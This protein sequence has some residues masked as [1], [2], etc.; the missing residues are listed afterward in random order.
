MS[1]NSKIIYTLTDEAPALATASLLPIIKAFTGAADI[2]VET[3][4]ISLAGRI[5]ANFSDRL[6]AEQQTIDALTE[7]GQIAKLPEA[8]IVKLPN[9]SAS[10][11]QLESAIAELQAHGYDIPNYPSNPQSDED[12][13]NKA[14][15]AKVL[16]SAVNPVLREGNSDRRAPLSVKSY[17]K[18]NPHSMG[19]WSANSKTV[20]ASMSEGDFYGSEKSTT[21][22]KETQ[23][24]IQFEA[25]DGSIEELKA[26]ASLQ[27]GEVIDA[28]I[29]SQ[30]SLRSFLSN[31][32]SQAKEEN[33]LFSVHM[34]ATMMKVSDPIIFGQVVSVFFKEVF[35]KH[36]STF[37]EL[38][39]SA[40]NGLGDVLT[41]IESLDSSKQAEILADI[42]AVYAKRA[43]VAMVNSDKGITNLN[44]PSDVIIDASMPA[45]IRTSGQMWNKNGELQDTMAVIPD[46]CY[47]GVFKET[48]EFC[49]EHGAF[50]PTT[51]GSVS[52]VGLMAQKAQ[53]YGSHDKTF[54]MPTAGVVRVISDDNQTLLEQ[55][56]ESGDIFRMCQVKDAPIQDW[57]KLAVNR[58]RSTSS[59][60][61]FWLDENR[62]HDNQIIKKVKNYLLD[63]DT[64]SLDIQI[65]SPEKATQFTLKRVKEGGDT[66]SV[67]GNVLRDYL[68]DLFP[69]LELGTSAKM[70]S[71]VP[72]MNGG[73]LFETGAGGSA[74]KHVQ[75][76]TVENHLRWD[77]LGEFLALAVSLEHLSATFDMPKA[78]ILATALDDAT[79]QFLDNNKSPSRK[80]GELDNRGSHFYLAMYWAQALAAQT[81]D[82]ELQA[83]F[84]PVAKTL[85]DNESTI[86]S[87]LNK[88]QGTSV[89]LGG[90]YQPNPKLVA[91]IMRPSTTLN[92]IINSI[93]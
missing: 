19:A 74:P 77:S 63:H 64:T 20:V 1:Q 34:K 42:Q 86:I 27:A 45:M 2:A 21:I 23:F 66:I 36:A 57:V 83:Q 52:N 81:Q 70:L 65:M 93:S 46:R 55:P 6:T 51:M 75:Q 84:T 24:S 54:Q 68:T 73:G 29:M 90:Y 58:A 72:L 43:D 8:N 17:A 39:I 76:L 80:V 49:K 87:E 25:S 35:D 32:I 11:P 62:A 71:I 89:D 14:I 28:S 69:I 82:F 50:D 85:S 33:I 47:A 18:K 3:R 31:S 78:Q 38:G 56:V 30:A 7:L 12:R 41:K 5:L 10:I 60:A 67:T 26:L 15:F 22:D 53:E 79:A 40:N 48:I 16:G 61:I 88:T 59:P 37:K 91:K 13:A 4:D 92:S 44:V 9:I